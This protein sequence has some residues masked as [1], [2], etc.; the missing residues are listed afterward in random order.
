MHSAFTRGAV[1]VLEH[2]V[3]IIVELIVEAVVALISAVHACTLLA[4]AL[5]L[6]LHMEQIND[7]KSS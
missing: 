3:D 1:S 5:S 2:D 7:I 6:D 4:C